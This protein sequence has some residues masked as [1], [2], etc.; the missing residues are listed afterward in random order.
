VAATVTVFVVPDAKSVTYGS[1]IPAYTFTYHSGSPTGPVVTPVYRSASPSTND[2]KTPVCTSSYTTLTPVASSPLTITCSG[3]VLSGY[4]FNTTAT[5]N[6]TITK[7][8]STTTVTCPTSVVY[9][10][11]ALTPCTAAVTG[12][13]GLN[14]TATV[15]YVSNTNVGTATASA[16]YAGDANHNGSTGSKTF[17]ITAAVTSL[18]YT[19]SR[20]VITPATLALSST[21]TPATCTGTVAYALDRNPLTGKTGSYALTGTAPATTGWQEGAYVLTSSLAASTNCAAASTTTKIAVA[22]ALTATSAAGAGTYGNALTPTD[23]AFTARK[24]TTTTGQIQYTAPGAWQ[25]TGT[26]TNYSKVGTTGTITGTGTLSWWNATLNAGKGGWASVG[27]AIPV[28]LTVTPTTVTPAS[29][30][31]IAISF[32][33]TPAAG[34]PALPAKT[35]QTLTSGAISVG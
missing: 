2:S 17:A 16:T 12:V 32:T 22:A 33:Y 30:G 4:T 26:S 34:Q 35:A 28:T 5:A 13:G 11:A 19:G 27:T 25:F 29:P 23:F 3:G 18:T 24:T 1:A 14:T 20:S 15:T 9:T 8:P 31:T 7:A 6:L 21:R 10:G